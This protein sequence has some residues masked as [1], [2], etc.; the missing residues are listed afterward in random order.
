MRMK[1]VLA[2]IF[3]T[4][5]F[6]GIS[7]AQL[8]RLLVGTES[9]IW[10]AASGGYTLLPSRTV[11]TLDVTAG[12]TLRLGFGS[13]RVSGRIT[14]IAV[15]VSDPATTYQVAC[16]GEQTTASPN[17]ISTTSLTSSGAIS[18]MSYNWG[19]DKRWKGTCR[20]L[21]VKLEDGTDRRVKIR[22]K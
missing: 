18:E 7:S 10:R 13:A 14:S 8:G 17:G 16:E 12:S 15:D 4:F 6:A 22:F 11:G 21:V 19:T 2:S 5:V 3:A 1:L 20:M 9:G